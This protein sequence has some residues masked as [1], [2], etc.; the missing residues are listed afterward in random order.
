VDSFSAGDS[1]IHIMS[2]CWQELF[3]VSQLQG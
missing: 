2:S 1:D 3:A